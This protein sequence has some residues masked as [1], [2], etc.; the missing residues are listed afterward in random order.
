MFLHEWYKAPKSHTLF[1]LLIT[2]GRTI[3][4]IFQEGTHKVKKAIR[5]KLKADI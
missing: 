2:C 4:F 3:L 1:M 5:M